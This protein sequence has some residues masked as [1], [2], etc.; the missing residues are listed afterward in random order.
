MTSTTFSAAMKTAPG[1]RTRVVNVM[2]LHLV[3]RFQMILAPWMIMSFIFAVSLLIGLMF[4]PARAS[5]PD[6][7]ADFTMEFNGAVLYF[8]IY[9]LVLAVMA[10]NQVFPFAQSYSVTRRD[11]YVG[12][13]L[14]FL[15]LSITYSIVITVLG[16]IEDAT[17]GWG[18]DVS[19][20]NPGFL[21]P[22]LLERFSILVVMFLFFFM[23]GM[24]TASVY[25][26]WGAYGMYVFFGALALLIL[27]LSWLT[28]ATDSWI[29]VGNWMATMG[30]LGVVMWSL[31][32]S[33]L[34][35]I[36][37]Y[38]ILRRSTPRN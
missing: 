16:W 38:L 21:G 6:R 3:N 26:R 24:A 28:T 33:G 37:G 30:L 9:M 1:M 20:F 27:G 2:R 35:I 22:N 15:T 7:A 5:R 25:V 36:T 23:V 31:A 17:N 11:F 4:Q 10:I 12:T 13:I 14:T 32:P 29:A 8:L 19:V 18:L 34:A